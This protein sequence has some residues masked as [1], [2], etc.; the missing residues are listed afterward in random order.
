[1][2]SNTVDD[3]LKRQIAQKIFKSKI[4]AC[5]VKAG[6]YMACKH[7]ISFATYL[8]A[9]FGGN[10]RVMLWADSAAG[11][12]QAGAS[13]YSKFETGLEAWSLRVRDRD[14]Q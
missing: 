1:M 13:C 4:E 5:P 2:I 6:D 8:A 9:N 3:C 7:C 11:L 12:W 14:C 10:C